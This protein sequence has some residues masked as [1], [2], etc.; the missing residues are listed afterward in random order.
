MKNGHYNSGRLDHCSQLLTPLVCIFALSPTLW[1]VYSSPYQCWPWPGDLIWS[2]CDLSRGFKSA[3]VGLVCPVLL[4]PLEECVPDSG[5]PLS[6]SPK[7]ETWWNW[8]NCDLN[9][10]DTS[11]L[12]CGYQPNPCQHFCIS[13]K[14]IFIYMQVTEIWCW[15]LCSKINNHFGKQFSSCL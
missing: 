6:L 14:S 9:P 1:W 2:R 8:D 11:S 13:T 3:C 12:T 10:E 5:C 4:D 15:F 7:N